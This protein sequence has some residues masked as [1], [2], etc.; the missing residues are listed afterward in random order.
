MYNGE[1]GDDVAA[2]SGADKDGVAVDPGVGDVN[3]CSV[4]IFPFSLVVI[5]SARY[6]AKQIT[7]ERDEHI[8]AVPATTRV[9]PKICHGRI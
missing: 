1:P 9:L 4:Y 3:I 5:L 8:N 2:C 7:K 6:V